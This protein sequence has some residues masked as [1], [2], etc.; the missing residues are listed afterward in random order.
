MRKA[1]V[2]AAGQKNKKLQDEVDAKTGE[3]VK[4]KDQLEKGEKLQLRLQ[5]RC[6]IAERT[7]KEHVD[8]AVELARGRAEVEKLTKRK[9]VVTKKMGYLDFL[10]S[11]VVDEEDEDMDGN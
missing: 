1:Q 9:E 7:F 8:V 2:E 10:S 3:I 11:L 4:L 5:E 6:K